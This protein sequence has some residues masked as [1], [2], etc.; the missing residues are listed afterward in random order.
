MISWIARLF[1]GADRLPDPQIGQRY[2]L[3]NSS[4]FPQ[5]TITCRV[6]GVL[7]GWVRYAHENSRGEVYPFE[8]ND[9]S[10]SIPSFLQT[11]KAIP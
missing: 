8:E 2:V 3:I 10:S 6:T 1:S 5:R 11:W 9:S 7:N 4:P